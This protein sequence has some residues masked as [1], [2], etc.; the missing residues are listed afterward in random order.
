MYVAVVCVNE[1]V[2]FSMMLIIEL[3]EELID[4]VIELLTDEP[5]VWTP[6]VT[7]IK[8]STEDVNV[9]V[10]AVPSAIIEVIIPQLFWIVCISDGFT[11]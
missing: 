4:S 7:L 9:G 6:S 11:N 1:P 2:P 5:I 10:A 8:E 3:N